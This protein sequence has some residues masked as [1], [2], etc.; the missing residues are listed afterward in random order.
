MKI[1]VIT[2]YCQESVEWLMQANASVKTQTIEARHI[3]VCD[4]S[5]PAR[6]PDFQGTHIVLPR[7]HGDHG[8]T[9]RLIGCYN[10]IT[11]YDAEAIA[12]L[13]AT[14]WYYPD[15]LR[16]LAT[17]A[18]NTQID[19]IASARMLHRPDGT[20]MMKCPAVDG[21][22]QMSP[23]C[24]LVLRPA[25][26]HLLAWVLQR[27]DTE[28]DAGIDLWRRLR[29]SGARM[30]FV[31]RPSVAHQVQGW[32]SGDIA[33]GG[34]ESST[35]I[36]AK[37]GNVDWSG[38]TV[39]PS[40][41]VEQP[42]VFPP[43]VAG[44]VL[45]SQ[46]NIAPTWAAQTAQVGPAPGDRSREQ[47]APHM[48]VGPLTM[49]ALFR[50]G[51]AEHHAALIE[52]LF[53]LPARLPPSAWSGHIP[54]LF[55]LVRMLRPATFVELG[56]HTGASLIAAASAV[57]AYRAPTQLV[58]IDTFRGD[59]HSGQYDGDSLYNELLAYFSH[60]FPSVRLERRSFAEAA[61]LFPRG[62]ID[63]LHID[64]LHT[65][66]AVREDFETW[67][68]LV[69]P[70]GVILMHDIGVLERG[71]GVHLLWEDLKTRFST[72]EFPHSH[73][74][75]I[76]MR[77]PNDERLRPLAALLRDEPALRAYQGL[78]AEVARVLP[79]RM[80]GRN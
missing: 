2:P 11:A 8:N 35:L 18:T 40:R 48:D 5:E 29:D 57:A 42:P 13:D 21:Q 64:G 25:F 27:E 6:I 7:N 23:S 54:F 10:A 52:P 50:T 15:H 77:A 37:A 67:F 32:S 73:G 80:Q 39:T 36:F 19:V 33:G 34:P 24:L 58:G 12:F 71:F 72:L 49:P 20:P 47:T 61:P 1:C 16:S 78:V 4:G 17:I 31:D 56:V 63:M 79:E 14:D 51:L 62:S 41:Q 28:A 75:G 3:L 69:S 45:T 46:P 76:I 43:A 65:Y 9:P 55:A 70:T 59:E 60:A 22:N 66:E 38:E 74:L 68:D 53:N 44:R 30:A 26:A